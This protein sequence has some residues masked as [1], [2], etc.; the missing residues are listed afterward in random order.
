VP[1]FSYRLSKG[2]QCGR[3]HPLRC[4]AL[5]RSH[6]QINHHALSQTWFPKWIVLPLCKHCC[7]NEPM[8]SP[9]IVPL[10]TDM[11]NLG[12]PLMSVHPISLTDSS[13]W[14][15][16]PLKWV[17]LT[18][19][20]VPPIPQSIFPSLVEC[21]SLSLNSSSNHSS[22]DF[23]CKASWIESSLGTWSVQGT[24]TPHYIKTFVSSFILILLPPRLK[25]WWKCTL[26][27]LSR[28][29]TSYIKLFS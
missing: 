22:F 27:K 24:P 20:S 29:Y 25:I 10:R 26:A 12:A 4:H 15:C 23:C 5:L 18:C 11:P 14:V 7:L 9:T 13:Y 2:H 28:P 19:L 6:V 8:H 17:N 21:R 3:S 16:M 1:L